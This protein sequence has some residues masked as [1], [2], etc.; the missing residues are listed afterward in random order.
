[1]FNVPAATP[2]TTPEVETTVARD[3][4]P[5]IQ[6]PPVVASLSVIVPPIHTVLL[7]VIAAGSA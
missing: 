3:V 4:L 7:P 6:V 5:L 2:V 1:M